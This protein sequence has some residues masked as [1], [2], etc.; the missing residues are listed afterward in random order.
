MEDVKLLCQVCMEIWSISSDC[1]DRLPLGTN[2]T[3]HASEIEL[4]IILATLENF[5]HWNLT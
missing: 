1:T 5:E 3:E 2:K 4:F